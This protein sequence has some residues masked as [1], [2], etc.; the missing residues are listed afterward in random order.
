MARVGGVLS[1]RSQN[2]TSA[3]KAANLL[4]PLAA[5]LKAPLFKA[6]PPKLSSLNRT[7]GEFLI[8]R[9]DLQHQ[10]DFAILIC[11][12]TN[13][14]RLLEF[15]I[16]SGQEPIPASINRPKIEVTFFIRR[17]RSV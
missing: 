11:S 9:V 8:A 5:R 12:T 17:Y 6:L 15:A 14:F 2:G 4:L 1:G 7:A 10:F 13:L 3:A 16:Q